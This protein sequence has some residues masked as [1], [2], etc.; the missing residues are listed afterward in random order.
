M[1]AVPHWPIC[2]SKIVLYSSTKHYLIFY[3]ILN[4][5]FSK[6][7]DFNT[8]SQS[9]E[10]MYHVITHLFFSILCANSCSI[11]CWLLAGFSQ[12]NSAQRLSQL[13]AI[14]AS[15]RSDKKL[16][17]LSVGHF[18]VERQLQIWASIICLML[19]NMN[20]LRTFDRF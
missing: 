2:G 4:K 5:I 17:R 10:L 15:L 12:N 20:W 14:H 1:L 6:L 13:S 18:F 16:S 9:F 11:S 19:S 3:W 7:L 8:P